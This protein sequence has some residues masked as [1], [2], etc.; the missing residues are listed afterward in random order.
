MINRTCVAK[1]VV[2]LCVVG[3]YGSSLLAQQAM[4]AQ[5]ERVRDPYTKQIADGSVHAL[6]LPPSIVYPLHSDKV[7][8][9]RVTHVGREENNPLTPPRIVGFRSASMNGERI[10]LRD[11]VRESV[12]LEHG[13]FK[14]PGPYIMEM[15]YFIPETGELRSVTLR[16]GFGFVVGDYSVYAPPTHVVACAC[17]CVDADGYY[18]T[19]S[20]GCRGEDLPVSPTLEECGCDDYE[21][22][23]CFFDLQAPSGT[24]SNYRAAYIPKME[25][26]P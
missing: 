1:V 8:V 20:L 3:S 17:D 15:E 14:N 9:T 6:A 21:D 13:L 19:I 22:G 5:R 2:A 18:W 25:P 23:E 26:L 10:G 24:A 11:P 4:E 12:S 7:F 16:P